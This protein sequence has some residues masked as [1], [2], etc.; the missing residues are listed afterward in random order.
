MFGSFFYNSESSGNNKVSSYASYMP[1]ARWISNKISTVKKL[2]NSLPTIGLTGRGFTINGYGFSLD[3]V[4][5][6][7]NKALGF[8]AALVCVAKTQAEEVFF[9]DQS[10]KT[11]YQLTADDTGCVDTKFFTSVLQNCNA[12]EILRAIDDSVGIFK[13]SECGGDAGPGLTFINLNRAANNASNASFEKCITDEINNYFAINWAEALYALV[14]IGGI[15]SMC[16]GVY[17]YRKHCSN[18]SG[19][20]NI[21]MTESFVDR[22]ATRSSAQADVIPAAPVVPRANIS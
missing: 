4:P 5:T 8:F 20:R 7:V 19:Y 15:A 18:D 14:A 17:C 1:G 10:G 12:T 13:I 9:T 2:Y 16:L 11:Y 21:A 22:N 6:N 3:N